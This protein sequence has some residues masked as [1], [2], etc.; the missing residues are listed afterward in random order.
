MGKAWGEGI[1]DVCIVVSQT[2]FVVAYLIFV[3]A[4]IYSLFG[5]PRA[6]TIF[7]CVPALC[8]LSMLRHLKYLTPV[9]IPIN[10]TSLYNASRQA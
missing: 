5:I 9:G 4:N 7:A 8:G 6:V 10:L 2:A 3:A 1:V